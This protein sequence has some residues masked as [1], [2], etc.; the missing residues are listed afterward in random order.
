MLLAV[1]SGFI[2]AACAPW[3]TRLLGDRA[4]WVL[5]LL[6]AALFVYFL[7]WIPLTAGGA[8]EV[9]HY[10]WIPGLDINLSFL[11]DGL[12]LL[13]ALLI[14]GIGTFIIIYSGGY[15]HGHEYLPRFYGIMF[16]FMAAM[17]G[18]VLSNNVISL[19]MFWELTSITS[20]LLIGF[21]HEDRQAR[22]CALQ[23]LLVTVAGG[24]ALLVG[25]IMMAAA[26]GSFELSELLNSGDV[27]REYPLYTAMLIL[28]LLGT[29]TKSAQVPFHFW[30]PNAMV[31]P[32]PVSAYLHSATMVKAGVYLMARLNPGLGG[33]DLWLYALGLVGAVTMFT[34][35]FMALRS[36]GVKAM[37]AYSTIMALGTLTML[38]GI[39][40]EA[41]IIAAMAFLLAHALYKAALF[42]LAGALDHET[43]TKDI[44]SMGGLRR[45]MPVSFITA[46][47]AA[48]SLAGL[49]PLFG[50]IAK[51]LM[52][53]ATLHAPAIATVT[54]VLAVLSAIMIMAVA[55]V[56]ALR[57]FTGALKATPKQP[58]EAP[59]SML[60]GPVVL[61]A[62]SLVFGLA[63]FLPVQGILHSA[64]A[65][66]HGSP[67]D[68]KLYLWH[69]VNTPLLL[70]L[71]A[72]V[73]G[74]AVFAGWDRVLAVYRRLTFID[75]LGPER[76]YEWF[77]TALTG[78][79]RWQTRV[80]QNGYMRNYLITILLTT[81]A[82]VGGTFF[83]HTGSTVPFKSVDITFYEAVV[84]LLIVAGAIIASLM[85]SRLGAVATV[86]MVGFGVA[87]IYVL[88]SAPDLA[89]TQIMVETLTVILLVLVLYRLPSFLNLSS[90]AARIRDA[91]VAVLFGSMMTILMLAVLDVDGVAPISDQLVAWSYDE[92]HGRNI[93]NVILVDFRALDTLGEIF[94]V[95]LAAIGVYAMIRLRAEDRQS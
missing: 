8:A 80:L 12:S 26:G 40:T 16:A 54:T 60:A 75:R 10:S 85:Q 7:S 92:G 32:T 49:P 29:F 37:L 30:L 48:L 83:I 21:S 78:F 90:M 59:P 25:L 45:L 3:L 13:F 66:V 68:F 58:H 79:A 24:L 43:G 72:V 88:F 71:L 95:G 81:V 70:S 52:F 44:L 2:L 76:G 61:A 56:F 55:A 38:I 94:V 86:G 62:L 28:I 91:L 19:F 14:S 35:S 87:L 67:L 51:E 27:L 17:L 47:V 4:G 20:Y 93:V 63:G 89:I 41:A 69:G 53:E 23:G 22:W 9:V 34:G 39:G 46:C 42:M 73:A 36:T 1:L 74:L 82:L 77:M 15:L 65:A 11:V 6:P 50:F 18:V 33:T 31:A 64:V 84:A 5:A 57:P